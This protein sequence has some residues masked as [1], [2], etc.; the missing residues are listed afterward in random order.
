MIKI[1][2]FNKFKINLKENNKKNILLL[3]LKI[4]NTPYYILYNK[5]KY[6][7]YNQINKFKK[8]YMPLNYIHSSI[9]KTTNVFNLIN[10]CN[11]NIKIKNILYNKLIFIEDNLNKKN[12]KIEYIPSNT[13]TYSIHKQIIILNKLFN[14]TNLNLNNIYNNSLEINLNKTNNYYTI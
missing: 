7:K 14:T 13:L 1:Y 2:T 8:Y 12:Y 6:I 3:D 9:Q 5:Y 10:N 4:I 11:P